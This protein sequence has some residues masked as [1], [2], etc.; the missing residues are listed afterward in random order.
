L[1]VNYTDLRNEFSK[2]WKQIQDELNLKAD[3]ADL[4]ELE[5]TLMNRLNDII[6]ALTKQFADKAETKKALKLLER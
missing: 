1:E 5:K 2:W 3:R 6:T 4:E